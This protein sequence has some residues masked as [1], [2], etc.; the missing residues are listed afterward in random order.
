MLEYGGGI[1]WLFTLGE[2][3]SVIF[4]V[5]QPVSPA[6]SEQGNKTRLDQ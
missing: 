2:L 6:N 5:I 1:F 4:G 3:T